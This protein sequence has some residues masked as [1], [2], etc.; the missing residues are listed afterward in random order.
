MSDKQKQL[1]EELKKQ[2]GAQI[3]AN[4]KAPPPEDE[5]E[6]DE[7]DE[8]EEDDEEEESDIPNYTAKQAVGAFGT[9]FGFIRPFLAN[10]KRGLTYVGI[11]LLIETAFNVMMP[12]SLKYLIDEVFE[13]GNKNELI[14]ILSTLGIAG[15]LT[16]CVA[17]WYERQDARVTANIMADVHMRLF[18]YI[19]NL[20]VSFYS[21]TKKG[22]LLSRFSNDMNTLE[23]SVLYSANW[24]FLPL[25]E[26]F[27]GLVLM[28]FLNTYLAFVALLIFPLVLIGPRLIAPYALNASYMLKHRQA[29]SLGVVQENIGGQTV[30]K[31]FSLQK[32]SIAAYTVRNHAVREAQMKTTF[33]ET[34]VER[35]ITITV[36]LLHLIVFAVGAYLAFEGKISVGTFIAFESVF[37]EISY[38]I[39]HV[40]HFIPVVI[41]G[42][43]ATHHIQEIMNEPQRFSDKKDAY[44]LPAF[45]E[46][47]E[48]QKAVFSYDGTVNQLHGLD[49]KLEAGKRIAIVGPS[50]AGKS[51]LL[52]LILRLYDPV[53]GKILIDGHDIAGVTRESLRA[54]MAVVFQENLLFNTTFR[55][56]IRLGDL[57]ATDKQVEEAAKAAEIHKFIKGLPQG[58]DTLV[59]ERGDTLSGGQ[60]QRIAIARALLRNPAILLLDEA[61][62]A[63]DQTTES[64][65]NKTLKKI[66]TGRTVLFVTHRLTSVTDMDEIVV[67]KDGKVSER[68]THL[69]LIAKK[70]LY[71]KLW[72]DQMNVGH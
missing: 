14:W 60:R 66:G 67:M 34:M 2:K 7:E 41:N 18:K 9:V 70:G 47:I 19:Q 44:E 12:L 50:G 59:G 28:F 58:Y 40:T 56:N 24:F 36:L 72:N 57:N 43:G 54:Q 68:G 4:K 29:E 38:N 42:A 45:K 63:L 27:S 6:D 30:I 39:A 46:S 31:A 37:W 3:A 52:N 13:E 64:S 20:P 8:E 25:M 61:T 53:D 23:M 55:E 11:G 16:S 22:S 49:L 69:K 51:T 48:F 17:I 62:S 32:F 71:Q 65:I 33:L 15:V 26:L 1:D 35:S 21:K 5:E 10:H